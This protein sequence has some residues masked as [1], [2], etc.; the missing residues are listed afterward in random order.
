MSTIYMGVFCILI[1]NYISII[2]QNYDEQS[3]VWCVL[4]IVS[5]IL[6]TL[7]ILYIYCYEVLNKI[8]HE[9]TKK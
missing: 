7:Y 4:C 9:A 6:Y 8:I 1:K 3:M 2:G 5:I